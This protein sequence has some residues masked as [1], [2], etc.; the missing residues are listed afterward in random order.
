MIEIVVALIVFNVGV[1][2]GVVLHKWL[3]SRKSYV[4]SFLIEKVDGKTVYSLELD[5]E[6][7][8]LEFMDEIVFRVKT[9]EES[10]DR[11]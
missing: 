1:F 10:P 5:D 6:P 2:A 9:S 8:D 7:S 3:L 4:G 11:N